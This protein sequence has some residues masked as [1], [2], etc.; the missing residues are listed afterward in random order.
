MALLSALLVLGAIQFIKADQ[1]TPRYNSGCDLFLNN[2][3]IYC[4]GGGYATTPSVNV[5]SN[6]D[7]YYIDVSVDFTVSNGQNNWVKVPSPANFV[8]EPSFSFVG[9]KIADNTYLMNGGV[10]TNDAKTYMK[11][12][13]TTW[14]VDTNQWA[15]IT[16]D[17][18]IPQS[19]YST[20]VFL[21]NNSVAF[22]GGISAIGAMDPTV[23]DIATLQ[24]AQA[25][26]SS[27][28]GSPLYGHTATLDKAGTSIYYIGGRNIIY[29]A[30]KK[31]YN[32]PFVSMG[33]ILV[34]HTETT[35]WETKNVGGSVI[36][37]GRTSHSADL[38]SSSSKILIY[39]GATLDALGNRAPLS[40]YIYLYDIQANTYQ[41][42][43]INNSNQASG[44]GPLFCHT[45]VLRDNTLFI[46]FGIDQSLLGTSSFHALDVENYQWIANYQAN[47]VLSP[48]GGDSGSGSSSSGNE[49]QNAST[50]QSSPSLG[51][52]AIAGIVV[53]VLASVA[54]VG[55]AAFLMY[56]RR[57][58]RNENSTEHYP[59][60]WD[61]T[62]NDNATE[63]PPA[64][65]NTSERMPTNTL[66]KDDLDAPSVTGSI[67]SPITEASTVVNDKLWPPDGSNDVQRLELVKPDIGHQI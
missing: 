7:Q 31:V 17:S 26:S 40:D 10:G 61:I 64:N 23:N 50:N 32:H 36:P 48:S 58:K 65:F 25:I 67:T 56:R 30:T 22:L 6:S 54:V 52:G 8:L 29:D 4:Y 51:S 20:G 53:G 66:H 28:P 41:Q 34:F 38:L 27:P 1:I 18:G 5:V 33:S 14:N 60:Y 3:R 24:I 37:E 39:G 45:T 62:K 16:N 47:A 44:A 57:N 19:Y 13:T 46:F 43:T 42:I 21:P 63:I 12:Q 9:V 59:T 49:S 55:L 2:T 35:T 15:S 11:N